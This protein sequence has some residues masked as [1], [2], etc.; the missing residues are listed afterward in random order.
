ETERPVR[1]PDADTA[2]PHGRSRRSG[3]TPEPAARRDSDGKHSRP[4]GGIPGKRRALQCSSGNS[5]MLRKK[6]LETPPV[7]R[8]SFHRPGK[9]CEMP[10]G[11]AGEY[12]IP[13]A[14][15]RPN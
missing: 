3:L 7:K 11:R 10:P 5:V 15:E 9:T 14:P 12:R 6:K 1:H 4:F 13:P 8:R 2:G